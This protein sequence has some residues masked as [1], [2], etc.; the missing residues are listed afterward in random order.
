MKKIAYTKTFAVIF[1]TIT[2]LIMFIIGT[3]MMLS[4]IIAAL[5]G[6]LSQGLFD[7]L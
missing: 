7:V 2:Y 1:W 6:D 4:F 5:E 3:I